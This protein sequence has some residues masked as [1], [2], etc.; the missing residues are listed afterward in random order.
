[1]VRTLHALDREADIITV[2]AG[3][4]CQRPAAVVVE[5]IQGLQSAGLHDDADTLLAIVGAYAPA[6]GVIATIEALRGMA[7][8]EDSEVVMAAVR[9][10]AEHVAST[11]ERVIPKERW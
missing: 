11:V 8:W 4:G 9:W 2:L 3:T 1:V 10:N 6:N 5:V 7:L